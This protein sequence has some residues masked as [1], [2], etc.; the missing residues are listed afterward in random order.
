MAGEKE[1]KGENKENKENKGFSFKTKKTG[2]AAALEEQEKARREAAALI[3]QNNPE[4]EDKSLTPAQRERKSKGFVEPELAPDRIAILFDDSS[5]M[6]SGYPVSKIRDAQ[7]GTIEFLKNC[8]VNLVAC[9]VFPMNAEAIPLDTNLPK[10]A[11]IVPLI[12]ATGSTPMYTTWKKIQE[13]KQDSTHI[14]HPPVPAYTRVIIFSD[15]QP[16]DNIYYSRNSNLH[17]QCIKVSIEAKV[18]VD[19]VY[20]SDG[21]SNDTDSDILKEIAERTGGFY[22]KF[23]RTKTNFRQAFKYLTPGM[24]L[25]L[26]DPNFKRDVE[27]GRRK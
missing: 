22:L 5:S 3:K 11:A 15:G 21:G 13:L 9:G 18:P 1:N 26:Q 10:T 19:T 17:E 27:E 20:I 8:Q 25:M 16:T 12:A 24:R 7:E 4:Q 6:S 14:D 2:L 23:D